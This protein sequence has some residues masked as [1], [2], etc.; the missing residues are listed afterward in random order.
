MTQKHQKAK[1]ATPFQPFTDYMECKSVVCAWTVLRFSLFLS[2]GCTTLLQLG[3]ALEVEYYDVALCFS[4]AKVVNCWYT[5]LYM[6]VTSDVAV[7]C[8]LIRGGG[9]RGRG[10]PEMLLYVE[11]GSLVAVGRDQGGSPCLQLLCPHGK[12]SSQYIY[13]SL[14]P[15]LKTD[16]CSFRAQWISRNILDCSNWLCAIVMMEIQ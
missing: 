11:R 5:Q 12:W 4:V 8:S 14:K 6:Y 7:L 1:R 10:Y 9:G 13:T 15:L 16:D 3:S 2:T